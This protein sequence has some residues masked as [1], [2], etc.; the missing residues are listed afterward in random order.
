VYQRIN[1][2][3]QAEKIFQG[4]PTSEKIK[5]CLPV[6]RVGVNFGAA[7]KKI[8]E[9]RYSSQIEVI[10]ADAAE[11]PGVA[12]HALHMGFQEVFFGGDVVS[13][14][15]LQQEAG[16]LESLGAKIIPYDINVRNSLIKD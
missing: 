5:I 12:L 2:I 11:F 6:E 14:G 15:A 16:A 8:L 3:T 9:D 4:L 13:L 7:L 10:A 1:D